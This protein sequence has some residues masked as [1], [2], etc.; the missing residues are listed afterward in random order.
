MRGA[1]KLHIVIA[2][3][4]SWR[5]H[6]GHLV[7]KDALDLARARIHA[8]GRADESDPEVVAL[9]DAERSFS[10]LFLGVPL[11]KGMERARSAIDVA[12]EIQ[13]ERPAW[14]LASADPWPHVRWAAL[15]ST[16]Y[17]LDP[18]WPALIPA[19]HEGW[20][21]VD[22]RRHVFHH[23]AEIKRQAPDREQPDN[24]NLDHLGE[25]V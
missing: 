10:D 21:W 23:F 6:P 16:L 5:V 22:A 18:K 2:G 7:G 3:Q 8:F 11:A 9:L 14:N 13:A 24:D 12:A 15:Y 17:E 19:L 25:L 4:K 1:L 20:L